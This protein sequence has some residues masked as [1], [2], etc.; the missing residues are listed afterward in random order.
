M[1]F[2]STLLVPD[3][4]GQSYSFIMILQPVEISFYTKE[5]VKFVIQED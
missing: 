4:S 1:M 5:Y 3:L 2:T